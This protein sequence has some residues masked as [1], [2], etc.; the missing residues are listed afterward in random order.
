MGDGDGVMLDLVLG[1]APSSGR[2]RSNE[3][4]G[5]RRERTLLV[6]NPRTLAGH[7]HPARTAAQV[8]SKILTF[9]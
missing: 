5:G 4:F 1:L 2:D 3:F 6:W 7:L 8:A 9:N